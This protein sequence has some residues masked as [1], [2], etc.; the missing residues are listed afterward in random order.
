[1]LIF[2]AEDFYRVTGELRSLRGALSDAHSMEETP[3]GALQ[4]TGFERDAVLRRIALGQLELLKPHLATLGAKIT[5]MAMDEMTAHLEGGAL[6]TYEGIKAGLD[7]IDTQLRRELSVTTVFVLSP[8]E[9]DYFEPKSPLFGKEFEDKYP[10]GAAEL[11]EAAECLALGRPTACVFHLMRLMECG[12]RAAAACLGA[13]APTSGG[14]R[15][16]GNILRDI[17]GAMEAKTK[18]ATWA[19]SGDKDYFGDVYVFLDAVRVAWR[20]PTMHV[21][22]T[23]TEDQSEHVLVAVRGFM[24][25]LAS[26]CDEDGNPKA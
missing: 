1:M 15:N 6:L 17:R 8:H 14:D 13:P 9:Q 23:Y 12:L 2:K 11:D 22:K 26:R 3:D 10:P 24:M 20:N 25:K 5:L 7:D 21:E 4:I 16:W 19:K 18:G